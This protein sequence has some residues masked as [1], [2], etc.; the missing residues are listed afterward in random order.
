MGRVIDGLLRSDLTVVDEVGF[1]PLDS[2]GTQLLFRFVAAVYERRDRREEASMRPRPFGRGNAVHRLE[3][4]DPRRTS[5]RPM[6]STV[7]R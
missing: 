2:V 7:E 5:M 1:A 4:R 6:S 3:V